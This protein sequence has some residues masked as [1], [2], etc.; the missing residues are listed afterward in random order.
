MFFSILNILESIFLLLLNHVLPS[1]EDCTEQGFLLI[2]MLFSMQ[3]ICQSGN[4]AGTERSKQRIY[5]LSG[6]LA[7]AAAGT[8]LIES[9]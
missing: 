6:S 8:E 3:S 1:C 9:S 4:F 2:A 7:E 5:A